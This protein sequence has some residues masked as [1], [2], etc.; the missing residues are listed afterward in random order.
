M[1]KKVG[2]LNRPYAG[3][4]P[5]GTAALERDGHFL[6]RGA[7]SPEQFEPLRDEILAVYRDVPPD[8]RVGR[9][10]ASNAEMFR[11]Q[12]FNRSALCQKA[13]AHPAVLDILEPLLGDDCH[14]IACTAWRN[15]PGNEHAPRGQEWH[16]DGG[17]HVPRAE[18]LEWPEAI[19]Y[20]IFVVAA[21]VY[22]Q[23]C[24]LEDGP[25][26]VIPGSHTSGRVPPA[27]Q[28]WN[29]DLPYRGRSREIHLARAGDV[30]FFVSDSWHRRLPPAE[31]GSGRLFLQTNYGRR[32]IAQ[33]VLAPHEATHVKVAALQ[34]VATLRERELL[35]IHPQV[36][37]DG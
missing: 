36:F 7:F 21:H 18:G 29:L 2:H 24:R 35:G 34:R 8:K 4:A 6:L 1:L 25:T 11:Y 15:P 28:M 26:A 3:P 33:R 22:L 5:E 30:G 20:P 27:E 16:V 23:D 32:E 9:F 12:M 10:S 14:V 17:P 37:Y 13:I 31:N 19:P